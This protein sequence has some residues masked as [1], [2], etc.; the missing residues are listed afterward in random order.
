MACDLGADT[1][2]TVIVT[3]GELLGS[4]RSLVFGRRQGIRHLFCDLTVRTF[5]EQG[6]APPERE[7]FV[8]SCGMQAPR[9]L[10]PKRVIPFGG[11][12]RRQRLRFFID[13]RCRG[14]VCARQTLCKLNSLP[15]LG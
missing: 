6:S 14:H 10:K 5:V 1:Y 9:V 13:S 12:T 15:L 4:E 7:L 2:L 8:E 3:V 11:S